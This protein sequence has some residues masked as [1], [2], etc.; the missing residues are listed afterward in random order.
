MGGH[1]G[2]GVGGGGERNPV[3][4][5]EPNL[6]LTGEHGMGCVADQD[7]SVLVPLGNRPSSHQ[8]PELDVS[9]FSASGV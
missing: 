5:G 4:M 7:E 9:G 2:G 8:L 6:R 1:G 3:D